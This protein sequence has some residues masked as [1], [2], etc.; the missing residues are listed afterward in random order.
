MKKTLG[1]LLFV[2]AF[3][4]PGFGRVIS[5]APYSDQP[6]ES[7]VHLRTSRYFV[8][9]E[10]AE[11]DHRQVVLYDSRGE[12][13]PRVVYGPEPVRAVALYEPAGAA[14]MLLVYGQYGSAFSSDGG[15]SWVDVPVPAYDRQFT[16][17]DTGGPYTGGLGGR[18]R[19]GNNRYPFV[20]STHGGSI[21][22][23]NARG[24]AR[25][26]PYTGALIGQD[27]DGERFLL[28]RGTSEV[29]M[30]DLDGS[31][32]RK[33]FDRPPGTMYYTAGWITPA[34]E[35][36][37]ETR[38]PRGRH[39]YHYARRQLSFVAGPDG[40]VLR[41]DGP[42]QY[43]LRFFAIPTE[44]FRGAWMIQRGPGQPTTLMRYS[45]ERGI[46]TMWSDPAGPEVEAL[47]AGQSGQTLL[48][49]VHVPRDVNVAVPFIDPALAVW[50]VGQPYPAEYD[51]LFLNEEENKGFV[52]LDVDRLE[53]GEPFVFNSGFEVSLPD[54]GP[55][56]PPIGGGADVIQEWGVVRG[57]FKQRLLLP[58][59]ARMLGAFGSEW[60]TDITIYNPLDEPQDVQVQFVSLDP[61]AQANARRTQ[62]VRVPPKRI[63]V[64]DDVLHSLFMIANGG[65][66]LI[67][68][69]AVGVNVFGRTYTRS[70]EGT[71]GYGMQAV[72]FFNA[73]GPRFPLFFS[74]AFPAPGF[75]TNVVLT[76]TSGRGTGAKLTAYGPGPKV[77]LS[78]APFVTA[79]GG[80][81][82]VSAGG[83]RPGYPMSALELTPTRGTVI[84]V[85][86]AIDNITNDA[87]YF[88]PDIPATV[89]RSIPMIAHT[90]GPGGSVR[91]D[92]YLFNPTNENRYVRLEAKMWDK[93]MRIIQGVSLHPFEARVIPDVMTNL[94]H[95]I[96]GVARLRYLSD[97]DEETGAGVRVTSRT[98]KT[99][100]EGGTYGTLV[101]PLNNFQIA[102]PG[103]T[104]EILGISG[105]NAFRTNLSLIEL[106]QTNSNRHPEVRVRIYDDK[107][108]EL[109][110]FVTTIQS[111][112][113]QS[114]EDLFALRGLTTPRA[115]LLKVEVLTEGLV[116]AYTTLED[117]ATGDTTYLPANLGAKVR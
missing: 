32:Y 42:W 95:G 104:L 36:F 83:N 111:T 93:S 10:G 103:D 91:S 58:G 75:R 24:T 29:V 35:A 44:D 62:I 117:V 77:G 78:T 47:I 102:A 54:E 17:I 85:V 3:A 4:A 65:G 50:R 31:Y 113:T 70:G 39:L 97:G 81:L 63:T 99:T 21:V 67:F 53:E 13:E 116:A 14:P 7:G 61:A 28:S 96:F 26:L 115:A 87:T 46:E 112:Y 23:I 22:A 68:E 18:V 25:I 55:I 94:F 6:S 64:I 33:L 11:E 48:V 82:Q 59:V 101:P 38:E 9:L 88:P 72:D 114:F 43:D 73:A 19:I 37:V 57:S 71:Y 51:E 100:P 90:D 74:G 45:T 107:L 105:G 40:P 69:P 76:D 12:E 79:A 15:R 52:H 89:P 5:Y 110:S 106:S 41:D 66:S 109:D 60:T 20:I 86:V 2:L 34:G 1:L 80:V 108:Q 98:Y 84:P 92:L 56:S 27:R 8:L 30:I 49:Q 16:G